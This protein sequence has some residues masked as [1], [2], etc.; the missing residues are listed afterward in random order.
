MPGA[1]VFTGAD[2]AVE[3]DVVRAVVVKTS[4]AVDVDVDGAGASGIRGVDDVVHHSGIEVTV[5]VTVEASGRGR[6]V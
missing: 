2:S 3:V 5:T 1:G 6:L 4:V